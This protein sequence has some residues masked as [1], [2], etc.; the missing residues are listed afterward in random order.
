[1]AGKDKKRP[2]TFSL[3]QPAIAD[4]FMKRI[5]L[6]LTSAQVLTLTSSTVQILPAPG[7]GKVIVPQFAIAQLKYGTTPYSIGTTNNLIFRCNGLQAAA[8][9][10]AA[11]LTGTASNQSYGTA[12]QSALGTAIEEN[13]PLDLVLDGGADPTGGDGTLTVILYYSIEPLPV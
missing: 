7:A 12:A 9:F 6:T 13:Q 10:I 1:M 11:L 5:Q 2:A 3:P 8:L 4:P